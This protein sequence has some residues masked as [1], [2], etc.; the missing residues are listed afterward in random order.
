MDIF[1]E[2]DIRTPSRT[3]QQAEEEQAQPSSA[4]YLR[5]PVYVWNKRA[6]AGR[7]LK[8]GAVQCRLLVV[9]TCPSSCALITGLEGLQ[10]LGSVLVP[11][12]S[13]AGTCIEPG[14]AGSSTCM[15]YGLNGAPDVVLVSCQ[16]RLPQEQ[17][18]AWARGLLAHVHA[19][20]TVVLGSIPAENFRGQGDPAQEALV[21]ALRTHAAAA[22]P[23][24]A[25]PAPPMPTGTVASGA[26]ASLLSHCQ[27]RSLPAEM[28]LSVEMGPGCHAALLDPLARALGNAVAACKCE[29]GGLA[30]L[31]TADGTRAAA[32]RVLAVG[33]A[34]PSNVYI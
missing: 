23:G 15:L 3:A 29:C 13:L 34:A 9:A 16:Y 5:P 14:H 4:Q 25:W 32:M 26:A 28:L 1:A 2:A 10:V 18:G 27:V 6:L 24:Y 17:S 8:P 11:G 33:A 30:S 21:F 22:R 20:H 7:Q 19:G 31:L 12:I